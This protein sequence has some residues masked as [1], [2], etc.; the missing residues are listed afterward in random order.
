[1]EI[2]ISAFYNEA[3]PMDFSASIAEIGNDAGKITW[4]NAKESGF[5]LLDTADKLAAMR[6]W[7]KSSGGW[8]DE[9]IAAWSDVEL[10]ALFIQIISGDIREKGES[11]WEEYQEE[12]EAGHVSGCLFLGIDGETYYQLEG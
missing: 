9:E 12:S 6:K 1:M 10:N 8:N 4:N 5:N 2:N 3:N 7:A 11:T